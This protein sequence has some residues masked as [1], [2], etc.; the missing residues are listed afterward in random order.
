M[1]VDSRDLFIFYKLLK[2]GFSR[3]RAKEGCICFGIRRRRRRR[4]KF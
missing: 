1:N 3:V 4:R 2:I